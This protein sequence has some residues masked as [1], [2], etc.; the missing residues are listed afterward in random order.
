MGSLEGYL[1]SLK[2]LTI[3]KGYLLINCYENC[4]CFVIASE[5]NQAFREKSN[6]Q[7]ERSREQVCSVSTSLDMTSIT[8]D[9]T[10][11]PLDI[12]LKVCLKSPLT[13]VSSSEADQSVRAKS[14]TGLQCL[15]YARHDLDNARHDFVFAQYDLKGM[16]E[17]SFNYSEFERSRSVSSSVAYQLV[18]V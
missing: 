2:I 4:V 7:F 13:T 12:T 15:D 18:R 17:K 16:L 11:Y 9:M 6:S 1:G 8:L 5:A 3:K 10:S 14:R